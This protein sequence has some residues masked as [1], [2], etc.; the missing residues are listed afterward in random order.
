MTD[1]AAVD[2]IDT[3]LTEL[4]ELPVTPPPWSAV[5]DRIAVTPTAR[6]VRRF[7][8]G[9]SAIVVGAVVAALV[10]IAGAVSQPV[11]ETVFEPVANL[12]PWVDNDP[13]PSDGSGDVPVIGDG[14]DNEPPVRPEGPPAPVTKREPQPETQ[15]TVERDALTDAESRNIREEQTDRSVVDSEP[16]RTSVPVERDSGDGA[17]A[18]T[19]TLA[20]SAPAPVAPTT[21][22][23]T[24]T[25]PP[26]TD[27]LVD[28]DRV[29]TR[30]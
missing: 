25:V 9:W 13:S 14:F 27:A 16:T 18:P 29:R 12:L 4:G 10:G 19:T 7:G 24:T 3:M 26:P 21:T 8:L 17:T 11:R 6:P 20:D 15:R 2:E 22:G 5:V 23:S 30:D 28:G 1:D